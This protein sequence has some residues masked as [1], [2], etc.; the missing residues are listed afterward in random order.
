MEFEIPKEWLFE[1]DYQPNRLVCPNNYDIEF[2]KKVLSTKFSHWKYEEEYRLFIDLDPTTEEKGLYYT[3]FSKKLKLN[4]VIVGC[5]SGLSRKDIKEALG[6][7]H[8]A[9]EVFK[10]RPAF[11]TFDIVMNKNKKLWT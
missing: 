1:V 8:D 4:R 2:M 6:D 11:K 9:V 5:E 7:L 10:A 3:D